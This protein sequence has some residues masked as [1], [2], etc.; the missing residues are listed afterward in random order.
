[1]G[2]ST[3]AIRTGFGLMFPALDLPSISPRSE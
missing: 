2:M 1:L 3:S